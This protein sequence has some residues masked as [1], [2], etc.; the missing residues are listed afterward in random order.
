MVIDTLRDSAQY[1]PSWRGG[2]APDEFVD[3]QLVY[4]EGASDY[5]DREAVNN[6]K[7]LALEPQINFE[8]IEPFRNFEYSNSWGKVA[9]H[10]ARGL[11]PFMATHWRQ[12]SCPSANMPACATSLLDDLKRM[13][14]RFPT[15]TTVYL[16]TDYPIEMLERGFMTGA[17][18]KAHSDTFTKSLTVENTEAMQKVLDAFASGEMG[19]LRLTT[20]GREIE[21]GVL[22]DGLDITDLDAGVVAIIDKNIAMDAEVFLAGFVILR[23]P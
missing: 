15:L 18:V 4:Y 22:G 2:P 7:T 20:L 14:A 6:L 12:E 19:D 5:F 3:V 1:G 8:S 9:D 11:G 16:A 10:I 17:K 21:R 23:S 13:T